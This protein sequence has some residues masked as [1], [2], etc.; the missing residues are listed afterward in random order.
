MANKETM[1]VHKALCE[2]KLLDSRITKAISACQVVGVK[3]TVARVVGSKSVDQFK[4]DEVASYTSAVDLIERYNAIKRAVT[5]SNATTEV[6]IGG[7]KYTVAEA[8][9]MKNHGLDH[10]KFLRSRIAQ[11]LTEAEYAIKR[12]NDQA[13]TKADEHIQRNFGAKDTGKTPDLIE[14]RQR[15]LES[16][17]VE[18]VDPLD[19]GAKKIL[20]ALDKEIAD[21]TVEVDAALSVSNSVTELTIEY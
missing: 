7:E 11:A 16:I 14:E 10:K 1:T 2:L 9:A 4:I 13:E 12:H 15:Y 6:V 3:K 19:G 21:F 8:I 18:L 17:S 5:L 20:E